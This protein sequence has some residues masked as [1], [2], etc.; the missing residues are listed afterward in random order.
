MKEKILIVDD[1]PDMLCVFEE[2]LKMED[3]EVSCAYNGKEAL[4]L[5]LWY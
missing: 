3:Y 4:K 5:F 2:L 1:D